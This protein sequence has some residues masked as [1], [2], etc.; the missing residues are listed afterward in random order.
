MKCPIC[1]DD[2]SAGPR[3]SHTPDEWASWHL[4]SLEAEFG[5]GSYKL[6]EQNPVIS[7]LSLEERQNVKR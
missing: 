3:C 1:S 7:E 4:A 5:P 2:S 6:V